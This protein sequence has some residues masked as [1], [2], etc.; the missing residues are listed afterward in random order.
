MN[1]DKLDIIQVSMSD[2]AEIDKWMNDNYDSLK[3]QQEI[4][5]PLEEG[6]V[7][8]KDERV[9]KEASDLA[10]RLINAEIPYDEIL[11]HFKVRGGFNVS[12][13]LYIHD[14]SNRDDRATLSWKMDET[15]FDTGKFEW[16]T[17]LNSKKLLKDQM[18]QRQA[19]FYTAN[20]FSLFLYM[21]HAQ[22]NVKE[23]KERKVI[24]KKAKS[25]S[26][27]KKNRTVRIST[28]RYT[29]NY[30]GEKRNYER[31]TDAWTV[32]GHWRYYKKSGKRVWI[33]PY[34]KGEGETEGKVYK[35]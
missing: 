26:N 19:T 1:F 34:K 22:G 6:I 31:H 10:K 12:F 29:I 5:F 27:N 18:A 35:I 2:F 30:D 33:E 11:I 14:S 21:L 8:V 3:V 17:K 15:Y 20:I 32:R 13:D 4:N 7:L 25:K 24:R 23:E 28:T 9:S 16:E